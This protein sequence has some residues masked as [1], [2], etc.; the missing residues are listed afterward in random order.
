MEREGTGGDTSK[1][2]GQD[3]SHIVIPKKKKKGKKGAN[4]KGS[5]VGNDSSLNST[6]VGGVAGAR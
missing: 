6:V 1:N 3:D 2:T 5:I 4:K